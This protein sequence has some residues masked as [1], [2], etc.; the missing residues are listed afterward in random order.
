MQIDEQMDRQMD[1]WMD[2]WI[3][4]SPNGSASLNE[5]RLMYYCVILN[6]LTLIPIYYQKS[7]FNIF[8][9]LL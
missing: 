1:G 3:A 6:N 5:Y 4:R 8:N 2:G 7:Y 9:K